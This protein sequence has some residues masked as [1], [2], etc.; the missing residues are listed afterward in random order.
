M[1]HY[2]R[3]IYILAAAFMA[4]CNS[5]QVIPETPSI[6]EGDEV[7]FSG[8]IVDQ[9]ED[10]GIEGCDG[11]E[12][13]ETRS[14]Y[15]NGAFTSWAL[16]DKISISDGVN[17]YY[18][19][20]VSEVGTPAT[21]CKFSISAGNQAFEKPN[22][23]DHDYYVFYPAD[24]V[25]EWTPNGKVTARIYAE[26]DYNENA[27]NGLM[28]TYLASKAEVNKNEDNSKDVH[29]SFKHCASV[30][31]I[32]V[33]GIVQSAYGRPV[34]VSIMSNNHQALAGKFD[35]D[36]NNN[37]FEVC[38][39]DETDYATSTQSDVVTV[40]NIPADASVVRFYVLPVEIVGGLT[41]TVRTSQNE[42]YTKT[43]SRTIGTASS[44]FSITGV[45]SFDA[46]K[47][48]A[49]ICRP[50]YQ[51][52]NFG[53]ISNNT[54]VNDYM[55]TIPS[56]TYFS[57]I[58][59]VGA[60][61]AAASSFPSGVGSAA[62]TW[63]K[64]QAMPIYTASSETAKTGL[65]DRYGVRAFDLRTPYRTSDAIGSWSDGTILGKC[66]EQDLRTT[67]PIFHGVTQTSYGFI[68]VVNK[69]KDYVVAHKTEAI[70]VMFNK[71]ENILNAVS[72]DNTGLMW[73]IINQTFSDLGEDA[74]HVG[75]TENL[76]LADVR[77][78]LIILNRR[79][80][81]TW[82]GST[83]SG[84][85]LCPKG[86]PVYGWE[87][88][89]ERGIVHLN[90][91]SSNVQAVVQDKYDPVGRTTEEMARNKIKYVY[92]ILDESSTNKDPNCYFFTYTAIAAS[93][94]I[95]SLL[96]SISSIANEANYQMVT[97][98]RITSERG[99]VG[100][101]FGDFLGSADHYGH[102]YTKAVLTQNAKYVYN[103][104]SRC[105]HSGAVNTGGSLSGSEDAD[106]GPVYIKRK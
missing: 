22:T 73:E 19:Y 77:G 41:I 32:N 12:V 27:D 105:T 25:E 76:T 26:Q 92:P 70:T 83:K 71:E 34:A 82:N 55:A 30:V 98:N 72:T 79:P 6:T 11:E 63:S 38:D 17:R 50:Y 5:E 20:A 46:N 36:V 61:N 49:A 104:R 28:G 13:S 86:T 95:G 1:K 80:Q 52:V 97:Q 67:M 53:A 42:Y 89:I 58:S 35:Y 43:T 81:D 101:L 59:T 66:T 18:Q 90:S 62:Q 65:V 60:H 102:D 29:F 31:E 4:G 14:T 16:G 15:Q 94:S 54:K 78:K 74:I 91:P 8:V 56:N 45:K 37:R 85:E 7:L 84:F 44:D 96:T 75:F 68:D 23:A 69:L 93:G 39:N 103:G 51:S 47:T 87:D 100:Y 99:P 64:T 57:K 24:A 40:S 33:S 88:N 10:Q 106:N 48:N 2:Y 9:L 3:Y 21:S